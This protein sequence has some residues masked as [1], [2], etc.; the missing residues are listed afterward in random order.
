MPTFELCCGNCIGLALA[1]LNT[2]PVIFSYVNRP[3]LQC[4]LTQCRS[5]YKW[6]GRRGAL[7]S[8][9][10]RASSALNRHRLSK[11]LKARQLNARS[12]SHF[13]SQSAASSANK[14][15]SMLATDRSRCRS[16]RQAV[17]PDK[18]KNELIRKSR[19]A[20]IW[21]KTNY[22]CHWNIWCSTYRIW[23]SIPGFCVEMRSLQWQWLHSFE[24]K[25]KS[26]HSKLINT[27]THTYTNKHGRTDWE[28]QKNWWLGGVILSTDY[29]SNNTQITN[30]KW[31]PL[32][33]KIGL[34]R[35]R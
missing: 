23:S 10:E 8:A 24:N 21:M 26:L 6:P 1:V 31:D 3:W 15:W 17:G 14:S 11:M 27:H 34:T 13:S 30:N 5:P 32:C 20:R 12:R 22:S 7:L 35:A 16:Y 33:P 28:N 25:S 18:T 29:L 2:C 4:S 19:S 9:S